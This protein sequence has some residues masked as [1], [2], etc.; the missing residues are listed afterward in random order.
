MCSRD[1]RLLFYRKLALADYMD[2]CELGHELGCQNQKILEADGVVAD[3]T[4]RAAAKAKST[5]TSGS[6]KSSS[7][8]ATGAT[9]TVT[10]SVGSVHVSKPSKNSA[11][12]DL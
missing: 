2:A 8:M 6:T 4:A 3:D 12:E 7:R 9:T 1:L 10:S 5:A 11:K